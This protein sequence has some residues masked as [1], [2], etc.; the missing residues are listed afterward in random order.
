[1]GELRP[2]FNFPALTR[3][4]IARVEMATVNRFGGLVA[5]KVYLRDRHHLS[6]ADKYAIVG[7]LLLAIAVILTMIRTLNGG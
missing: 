6:K 7:T 2:V 3:E 1:M 4:Q 5:A